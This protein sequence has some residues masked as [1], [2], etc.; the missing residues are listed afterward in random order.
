MAIVDNRFEGDFICG[1]GC[2]TAFI[3]GIMSTV[4]RKTFNCP[5]PGCDKSYA[6]AKQLKLGTC[7]SSPRKATWAS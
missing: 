5:F 1:A 2:S 6:K 4:A 3:A 7:A